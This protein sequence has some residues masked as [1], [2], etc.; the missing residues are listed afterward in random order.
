MAS[1]VHGDPDLSVGHAVIDA[2]HQAL[3]TQCDLV[4]QHCAGGD[5][6]P[7]AQRF[8]QAVD[9]FKAM[10]RQHFAIEALLR[11]NLGDPALDDLHVERDEFEY[12][13]SEIATTGHFHRLEV[14]RFLSLWC[15]GHVTESARQL[16]ALLADGNA[17][18]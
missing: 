16:R 9:R 5:A 14:Q 11:A 13:A 1:H 2:Q 17:R 15:V 12:L 6:E 3:L 4:A 8:D 18:P 10:V 7:S